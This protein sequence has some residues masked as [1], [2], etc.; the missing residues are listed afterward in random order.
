MRDF[1]KQMDYPTKRWYMQS[2]HNRITY[3][4]E[5]IDDCKCIAEEVFFGYV[6]PANKD[7]AEQLTFDFGDSHGGN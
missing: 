2:M 6:L 7:D 5:S 4:I 3:G 1:I